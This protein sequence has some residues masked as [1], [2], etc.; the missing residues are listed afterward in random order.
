MALCVLLLVLVVNVVDE[1][2][3]N[4]V[5]VPL[6][7]PLLTPRLEAAFHRLFRYLMLIITTSFET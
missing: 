1:T 5:D 4:L 3:L 6:V 2:G 7:I